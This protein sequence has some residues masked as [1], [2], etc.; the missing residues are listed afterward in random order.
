MLPFLP[1]FTLSGLVSALMFSTGCA[2]VIHGTTQSIGVSS[3]PPGATV[4]VNNSQKAR[5]PTSL[6]LKRNQNH[7]FLFEK[8]GYESDSFTLTSSTS[9]WVWGNV[10]LGGLIGGMV[11]FASGGARKLSRDTVHVTLRPLP[12]TQ[13]GPPEPIPGK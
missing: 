6:E 11:D 9:G 1:R 5:T 7:T 8:D 10:L 13:S 4:T 12:E 2:T 3:A